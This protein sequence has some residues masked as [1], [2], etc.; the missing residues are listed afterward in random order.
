MRREMNTFNKVF[1][2]LKEEV[3]SKP[4]KDGNLVQE[5]LKYLEDLTSHVGYELRDL[6]E[7]VGEKIGR[8]VLETLAKTDD[9]TLS[10]YAPL[11]K[12]ARRKDTIMHELTKQNVLLKIRV[13]VKGEMGDGL[14]SLKEYVAERPETKQLLEGY[15]EWAL[16]T[17]YI[18]YYPFKFKMMEAVSNNSSFIRKMCR[19]PLPS[20]IK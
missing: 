4:A 12:E 11:L 13:D 10:K 1:K 3:L 16:T 5:D 7:I 18:F 14:E 2:E 19:R 9:E 6:E 17:D 8:E 15:I 20:N